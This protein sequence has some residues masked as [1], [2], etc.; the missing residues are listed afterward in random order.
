MPSARIIDLNHHAWLK[1]TLSLKRFTLHFRD[2]K[3]KPGLRRDLLSLSHSTFLDKALTQASIPLT[4][5]HH[6]LLLLF[7]LTQDV[8]VC[9]DL[10]TRTTSSLWKDKAAVEINVAVLHSY[11]VHRPSYGVRE[12]RQTLSRVETYCSP[13]V[14][15]HAVSATLD[16]QALFWVL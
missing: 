2:D 3:R 12:H 4:P 11:Q 9:M 16:T 10:D 7:N 13:C 6:S 14:T 1:G 8:A 5:P 15:G